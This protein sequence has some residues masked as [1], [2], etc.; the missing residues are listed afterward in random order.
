M[1]ILKKIALDEQIIMSIMVL[2][3]SNQL[4]YNVEK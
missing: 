4:N 3:G 2:H 1:Y